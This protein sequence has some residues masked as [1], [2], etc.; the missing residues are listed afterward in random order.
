MIFNTMRLFKAGI[1]ALSAVLMLTALWLLVIEFLRPP[2][3]LRLAD[4]EA[5]QVLGRYQETSGIAARIGFVQGRL[6]TEHALTFAPFLTDGSDKLPPKES[7]VHFERAR[8]AA[9]RAVHS[10]PLD[11]RAWLVLAQAD[12]TLRDQD[13]ALPLKMSY[14]V[15]PNE[16]SLFPVRIA[17]AVRSN[18]LDPELRGLLGDEVQKILT[19]RPELKPGIVAAYRNGTSEGKRFLEKEVG[20]TDRDLL[21]VLRSDNL[22]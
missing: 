18:V 15:G 10:T 9:T 11:A 1:A 21:S 8:D 5:R 4:A 12:S 2:I 7:A 13:P 19:T 16:E 14:Y 20:R 3:H 17:I 6:W 22:H